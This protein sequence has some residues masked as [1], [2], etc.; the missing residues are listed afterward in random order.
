[1]RDL[2]RLGVSN[3]IWDKPGSLGAGEP[4]R[5]RLHSHVTERM[6]HR[7]EGLASFAQVVVQ[8]RERLDGSGYRRGLA[9]AAISRPARILGAAA[10]CQAMRESRPYRPVRSPHDAA[11]ELRREVKARRYDADVVEAVLPPGHRVSR[12][13]EGP[14][15]PTHREVEVLRL[16]AAGSPCGLPSSW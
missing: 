11:A 7:S 13:R 16:L 4:E 10:A 14:A 9:E 8:R 1:V 12:R 5:V 15:G 3:S 2:E 6:L